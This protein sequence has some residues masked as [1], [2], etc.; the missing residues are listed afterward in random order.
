MSSKPN[1]AIGQPV[2]ILVGVNGG[3]RWRAGV[4]AAVYGSPFE[5]EDHER[6][7]VRA[8]NGAFFAGCHPSSIRAVVIAPEAA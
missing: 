4:V 8:G 5:S 1:F 6:I 2:E 7:D 3:A